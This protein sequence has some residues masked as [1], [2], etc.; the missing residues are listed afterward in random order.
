M[1]PPTHQYVGGVPGPPKPP[2]PRPSAA[3]FGVGGL[4]VLAGAVV[5]V[6]LFVRIFSAGFLSVEA[7]IPAD[8]LVH[9]VTVD[10]GGDRF[11]W[12]PENGRAECV[13]RDAATGGTIT[14]EPV[15]GTF[16][17]SGSS[18]AWQALARFDPGSG[19]LSVTCSPEEGPAQIGPALVVE[20]FVLRVLLAIVVPMVLGGIGLAVLIGT[21]LLWVVRPKRTG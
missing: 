7:T 21:G 11:L 1:T 9:E 2:K 4:L 19:R 10:A 3:W 14:L 16:T 6:V 18:E 15:D 8:G 13:V 20:D 5:G 12:E 17:R